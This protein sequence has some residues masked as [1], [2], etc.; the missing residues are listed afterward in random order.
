MQYPFP[1]FLLHS[2]SP[3]PFL[4]ICLKNYFASLVSFYLHLSLVASIMTHQDHLTQ[5]P[6]TTSPPSPFSRH[7]QTEPYHSNTYHRPTH[8][9]HS[10]WLLLKSS[11]DIVKITYKNICINVYHILN[12]WFWNTQ[13]KHKKG[14]ICVS[15]LFRYL[16]KTW[17][18]KTQIQGVL[19][20][21][22][23]YFK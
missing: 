23:L 19:D 22:N 7:P 20:V 18:I 17:F 12:N 3:H 14:L 13:E 10:Y 4:P 8:G 9:M 5:I 21:N 2:P 6:T 15:L 16:L 11:H 1:L